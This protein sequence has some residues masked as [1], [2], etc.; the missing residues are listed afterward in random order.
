MPVCKDRCG[1]HQ[2]KA[3]FILELRAI[4]TTPDSTRRISP[5]HQFG[6][7]LPGPSKTSNRARA[8][9]VPKTD[10]EPME[11]QIEPITYHARQGGRFQFDLKPKVEKKDASSG[12]RI[13]CP[14]CL[15]KPG[16]GDRWMCHCGHTWNT[17]DTRGK[18]PGCGFQWTQTM[19][20][21]CF[22]WSEHDAWYEKPRDEQ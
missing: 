19:C 21:S 9:R 5:Y 17:F 14:R 22:E 4:G 16:S 11:P 20:L 13:R 1:T 18:C 10:F 3:C 8:C 2:L 6:N 15:W 12:G 7:F